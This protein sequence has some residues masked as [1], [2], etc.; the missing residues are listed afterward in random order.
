[1]HKLR[2]VISKHLTAFNNLS[3]TFYY[4][5]YYGKS[6]FPLFRNYRSIVNKQK[7]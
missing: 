3:T 1:M 7:P 5:Y 2:T 4:T 6:N